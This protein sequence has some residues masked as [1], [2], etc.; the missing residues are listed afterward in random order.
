MSAPPKHAERLVP[1]AAFALALTV[2]V[3][4]RL[5]H[6][7]EAVVGGEIVPVDGDSLYHFKRILEAAASFP[8]VP[9]FDPSMNWPKG[10]FCPWPAGFDVLGAAFALLGGQSEARRAALAAVFPVFLGLLAVA[11]AADLAGRLSP[12]PALRGPAALSS[13]LLAALSPLAVGPSRFGCTDHHVAEALAMVAL[14]SW[15]VRAAG[16]DAAQASASRR[17]QWEGWGALLVAL[18]VWVFPGGALYVALVA[19]VL[20]ARALAEESPRLLGGGSA[21]LA[22]GAALAALLNAG[23]VRAHGEPF[24]FML[25][26]FLPAA[27]CGLA[28]GALGIAHLAARAAQGPARRAALLVGGALALA[29]LSALAAPEAAAQTRRAIGGWLLRGDPWISAIGESRS[30]WRSAGPQGAWREALSELGLGP[31]RLLLALA[32]AFVSARAARGRGL[33]FAAFL[34]AS[35]ALSVAQYRFARV[36]APLLSAAGGV[37]LASVLRLRPLARGKLSTLARALPPLGAALLSLSE[38]AVREEL[39]VPR[40]APAY[41]TVQAAFDLRSAPARASGEGVLAW[42]DL[43]HHFEVLGRHP[44]L[45]NPFGPYLDETSYQA[46]RG[47][48]ALDPE[49]LDSLMR[50]RDLGYLVAGAFSSFRHVPGPGGRAVFEEKDGRRRLDREYLRAVPTS[51]LILGGTGIPALGVPH[52]AH[53]FPR[54]ASQQLVGGLTV[55]LPVLWAFERVPGASLRGRAAAGARVVAALDFK[56]N[57]RPHRWTAWADA[58]PDGAWAMVVPFPSGYSSP[59]VSSAQ[60]WRIAAGNAEPTELEIP[61]A[62]VREG[63]VIEVG[64]RGEVDSKP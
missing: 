26:S 38:P 12:E 27:L 41:P 22:G 53:L 57:G 59:T 35:V 30:L 15:A 51:A 58:G 40:P 29:A 49:R 9:A 2:A 16:A 3:W 11:L 63:K 8:R 48:L 61:E 28:A 10:A 64:A 18:T 44:V 17:L 25:P 21:A 47:A 20:A 5:S 1:I 33:T 39:R 14:A 34:A 60:Q 7:M 43:G 23:A 32:G 46:A 13:A 50:E 37:A 54:F 19:A 55:E 52:S 31:L 24:S 4:A 42:W 45:V 56:E 62:S 6:A 36:A